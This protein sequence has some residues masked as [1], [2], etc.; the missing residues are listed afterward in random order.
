MIG[1]MLIIFLLLPESPWWLAAKGKLQSAEKML[2]RYNGHIEGYNVQEHLVSLPFIPHL[3]VST[4]PIF[5]DSY[6]LSGCLDR[7]Y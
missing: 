4:L 1:V 3:K 6:R 5:A 7:Y 2:L